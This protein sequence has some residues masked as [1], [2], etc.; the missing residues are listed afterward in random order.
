VLFHSQEFILLFLPL[1]IAAYYAVAGSPALRQWV[2]IACSIFF[3]AWWDVRFVPLLIGQVL[4]TYAFAALSNEGKR[5]APIA[6]GIIV[7][8][9]SIFSFKYLGFFLANIRAIG[10]S[11]PNV[12]IILPI[13][14]SFFSFQLISYL[15]DLRRG[16]APLYPLRQ[17]ALVVLLFPHLIAGPIVRHTELAPQF[18]LDPRREGL[19]R[20]LSLGILLFSIGLVQKVI[21]AE[22]LGQI[23][24]AIF[25]KAQ[26][27]PLAFGEAWTAALGFSFQLFFDFSGYSTMA[28][29]IALTLGFVFPENFNRP[30]LATSLRDFW[31]RWHMTLSAFLR[32]YVYI[33]LGGNRR[34]PI[35][36][37]WAT[38]VTMT[39]CGVW[40]GAAWTFVAWGFLHGIGMIVCRAWQSLGRPLPAAAAWTLTMGFVIMGWVLF[41]A[42]SFTVATDILATLAGTHG[43]GGRIEGG[44]LLLLSAAASVGLPQTHLIIDK[45]RPS[46]L[47]AAASALATLACV[48][49]VGEGAPTKFIYF[50]F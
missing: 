26:S 47:L 22:P 25:L 34:G 30:Y 20:R 15:V 32:D 45:A 4:A 35:V 37:G 36:F 1:T 21:L 42:P 27:A 14:I 39:L 41:R 50:Q 46:S 18:A 33:P 49:I 40:H 19:G 11:A 24:D 7:N 48:L 8:L 12:E 13:G 6:L 38:I 29:G 28:I 9:A 3:Y 31:R 44:G 17:F 16:A 23:V 2:L 43:F 10:F 5:A